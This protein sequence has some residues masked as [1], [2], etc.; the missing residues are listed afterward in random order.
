[1]NCE[2]YNDIVAADVD[3]AL[4]AAEARSAAEHVTS[5]PRCQATRRDQQLARSILRER[6]AHHGAPEDLRHRVLTAIEGERTA[7]KVTSLRTPRRRILVGA[8][9]ALLAV[10]LYSLLSPAA[11]PELVPVMIAEVTA[12]QAGKLE[13]AL[14]TSSVEQLQSFY[15][16]SGRIDF[17]PSAG[18]FSAHGFHLVGGSVVDVGTSPTALSV[19]DSDHGKV[20]CRRFREGSI[21][22][23]ESGEQLGERR[24]FTVDGVTFAIAR[25]E[26]GVLCVL[27]SSMPSELF[28]QHLQRAYA[29][30][31]DV[32]APA[33]PLL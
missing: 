21:D 10:V 29:T 23:P 18:D 13:I 31:P 14:R 19:Y 24:I 3:A 33:G 11:K 20:F 25:L 5:C 16:Q 7:G 32:A 1:M 4:T 8:I 26:G 12:A 22:V 6:A 30:S 27:A 9:A 17:E 15:R 2:Q 28:I